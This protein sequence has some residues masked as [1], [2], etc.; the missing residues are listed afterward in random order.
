MGCNSYH[1]RWLCTYLPDSEW[2]RH[3]CNST[4][5]HQQ[6]RLHLSLMQ[7]HVITYTLPWGVTPVTTSGDYAHTYQTVN[8]CDS[9][10]TAHITINNSVAT[11][12]EATACNTYTLPW[13]DVVT[14]SGDYAHTYQTVNGCDSV[15]TAHITINNSVCNIVCCNSM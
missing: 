9:V 5:H 11:S 6:Q 2:L 13:A 10:V 14:T 3:C 8:G 12:F 4:Y 1:Q 7:Q 15:V